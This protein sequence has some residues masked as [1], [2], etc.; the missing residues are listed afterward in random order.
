MSKKIVIVKC[1]A[2]PHKGHQGFYSIPS[3]KPKCYLTGRDLNYK[4]Q[5]NGKHSIA[6]CD[7]VIP[8]WCPLEENV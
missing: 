8:E 4:T 7:E 2:C 5:T 6:V 3:Y 1:E